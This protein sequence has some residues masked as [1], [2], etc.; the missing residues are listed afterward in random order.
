M[1]ATY[2]FPQILTFAFVNEIPLCVTIKMKAY[3]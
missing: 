2:F 1:K 3:E